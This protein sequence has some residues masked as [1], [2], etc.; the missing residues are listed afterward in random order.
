MT[1]GLVFPLNVCAIYLSAL[2]FPIAIN[3]GLKLFISP[4]IGVY[5]VVITE[6]LFYLNIVLEF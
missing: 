4:K 3:Y 6:L 5:I 1:F 2:D